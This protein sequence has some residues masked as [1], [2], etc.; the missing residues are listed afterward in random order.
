M[1]SLVL[2]EQPVLPGFLCNCHHCVQ[3]CLAGL[4]SLSADAMH[5]MSCTGSHHPFDTTSHKRQYLQQL[6]YAQHFATH[7]LFGKRV[8]ACICVLERLIWKDQVCPSLP[9]MIMFCYLSL[10]V[11]KT[12]LPRWEFQFRFRV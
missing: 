7:I 1:S 11:S 2:L 8:V 6:S 4:S 12:Q 5:V 9:A 3:L 10:C